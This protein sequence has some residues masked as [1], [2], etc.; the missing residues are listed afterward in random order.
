MLRFSH[1]CVIAIW[2]HLWDKI[3]SNLICKIFIMKKNHADK[4]LAVTTQQDHSDP[5]MLAFWQ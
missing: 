3:G 1:F 5:V 2:H 4:S